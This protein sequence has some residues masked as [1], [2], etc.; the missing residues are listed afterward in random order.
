MGKL[1]LIRKNLFL[2]CSYYETFFA[3]NFQVKMRILNASN[4]IGGGL[5]LGIYPVFIRKGQKISKVGMA[6]F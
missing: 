1:W 6:S 4:C 3:L 5:L 2:L